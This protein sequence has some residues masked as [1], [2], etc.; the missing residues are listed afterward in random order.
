MDSLDIQLDTALPGSLVHVFGHVPQH[1]DYLFVNSCAAN[2]PHRPACLIKVEN[3]KDHAL[4]SAPDFAAVF[5]ALPVG[6][7][8]SY[9]NTYFLGREGEAR[10]WIFKCSA[11]KYSLNSLT[12]ALTLSLKEGGLLLFP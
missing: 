2:A 3:L 8:S 1:A 7:D 12:S 11:F 5:A 10:N 6:Q 9:A 4:P